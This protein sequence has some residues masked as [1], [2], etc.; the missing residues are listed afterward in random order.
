[1]RS[2][3]LIVL[4]LLLPAVASAQQRL[5][6]GVEAH[7][8]FVVPTGEWAEEDNLDNGFGYGAA[9]TF[10]ASPVVGL[11]AGWDRATFGIGDEDSGL[12]TEAVDA[13]YRAGVELRLPVGESAPAAPFA[14][15]GGVYNTTTFRFAT[16]ADT[17]G[18]IEFE[19]DAELGFEA[20][21]GVGVPAGPFIL[22]PS[23]FFRTHSVEFDLGE[24]GSTASTVQ[25]FG[26]MLALGFGS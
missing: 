23:L 22:R 1:M 21:V 18:T 9:L 12:D 15:V 16:A 25:Y 14:R 6:I 24:L 20:A 19:S 3:A 13:G 26:A 10:R 11:Y 7:A 17:N 8:A 5:P 2:Y 4:L